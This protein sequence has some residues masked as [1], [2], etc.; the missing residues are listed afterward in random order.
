M[1]EQLKKLKED[2]ASLGLR[3][4]MSEIAARMN[5]DR[6]NFSS[7]YNGRKSLTEK[8]LKKFRDAIEGLRPEKSDSYNPVESSSMRY[9]QE[10]QAS[11]SRTSTYDLELKI[12]RLT[13][14]NT[15]LLET[16]KGLSASLDRLAD[17]NRMLT[18]QVIGLQKNGMAKS[19][20]RNEKKN[21]I[22]AIRKVVRSSQKD[23]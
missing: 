1:D 17:I 19:V 2:I 6:G 10:K 13:R 9:V 4:P 15:M 12:K 14:E 3:F 20:G 22:Q 21:N 7:Y 23:N 5:M 11:Y 18:E 8:F 16:L